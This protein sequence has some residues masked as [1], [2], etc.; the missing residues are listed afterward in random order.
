MVVG[1][2]DRRDMLRR[3]EVQLAR[4]ADGRKIW[5]GWKFE[6]MGSDLD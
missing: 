6:G 5:D 3:T 2:A 4:R 1:D